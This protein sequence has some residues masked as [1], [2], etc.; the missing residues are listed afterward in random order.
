MTA[1]ENVKVG[2]EARHQKSGPCAL[3]RTTAA[4]A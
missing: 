1:L 2:I 4:P 3:S